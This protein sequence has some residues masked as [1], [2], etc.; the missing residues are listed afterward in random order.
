[1]TSVTA[2][3]ILWLLSITGL[4]PSI[5]WQTLLALLSGHLPALLAGLRRV[6]SVVMIIIYRDNYHCG[7][8]LLRL[9][10]TV[11]LGDESAELLGNVGALH[12]GLDRAALG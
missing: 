7:A 11:L 10:S 2:I 5:T 8:L 1:M 3:R 12:V 6:I 9:L 4:V